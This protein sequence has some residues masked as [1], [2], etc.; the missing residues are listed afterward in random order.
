MRRTETGCPKRL[1]R[2]AHVGSSRSGWPELARWVET[3]IEATDRLLPR[4]LLARGG[5]EQERVSPCDVGDT[6]TIVATANSASPELSAASRTSVAN[7]NSASVEPS[8]PKA[9]CRFFFFNGAVKFSDCPSRRAAANVLFNAPSRTHPI[10]LRARTLRNTVLQQVISSQSIKSEELSPRARS[11]LFTLCPNACDSS[12][13][14]FPMRKALR[15]GLN[16]E[17]VLEGNFF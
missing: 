7:A 13:V 5:T 1:S 16:V 12:V 17:R 10:V 4:L 14:F 15:S 3:Q 11:N 2:A 8:Q 6:S 9:P